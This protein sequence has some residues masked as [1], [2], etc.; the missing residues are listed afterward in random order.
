[1][2]MTSDARSEALMLALEQSSKVVATLTGIKQQ[3]I[4]SGWSQLAAENVTLEML[5]K[6]GT[7]EAAK[8]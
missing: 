3:L 2:D 5:R 6:S 7:S 8:N 1:M 4:D